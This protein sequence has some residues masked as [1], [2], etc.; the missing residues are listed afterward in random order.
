MPLMVPVVPCPVLVG[1]SAEVG[2]L[3]AA[4]DAARA[5]RGGVVFVVG[6]AGIGKSRLV[7]EISSMAAA[8][9]V[10]VLRGRAVPGSGTA[11]F[12]PIAEALATV[13]PEARLDG[14][15]LEPWL[16]VLAAVVPTIGAPGVAVEAS[17]PVRG[18]AVL[19]LL[20][21]V[22]AP[23]GGLLLL[24]DLHWADPETLAVVEH[25]S[26]HLERAPV[27]CVAT[28]R[29]DA[30]SSARDL[31]RR[32]VSRRAAQVVE[33]GRLND[34]QVAAMVYG[35]TGGV[36]ADA[37]DRIVKLADGVPF[38]VEELLVSPGLPGSFADAV[39]TRLAE[40]SQHDR[41]LL[42]TAAAFGRH[43]DWRLLTSATGLTDPEVVD[44][45]ERGVA[46][47]LLEVQ[48][49]GFRFRH[50]LTAEAVLQS[51]IPPRRESL[52]AAALA[53][54]DAAHD[55][56]SGEWLEVA[57]GLAERSRQPE[58]AGHL[59]RASGED[60]LTRG[61]LHTAVA[62]LA[63]AA[64]LLPAGDVQD[65]T[66][67]RLIE[68]LALVGRVDDALGVGRQL[69]DRLPA[70]RAAAVHLRLAG[71]A[72]TA[73]RWEVAAQQLAAAL[74]LVEAT[75][76][77]SLRA[78]L[79]LRE[80]ELAIGSGDH[81]GA[82]HKA[83][84][85]LDLA[86]RARTPD[87]ECA[88][89]QLLGRCARR[90]SLESAEAWFRDALAT[91]DA[92]ERAVWRLHA[93]HELGTIRLLD[94]SAVGTLVEA[95]V[96]A[97]SLGAMAT[98]AILD[99]ELAAGYHGLHDLEGQRRHG[100]EAV[101]RGTELAL[102]LVVAYGW[103]HVA[104]ASALSGDLQELETAAAAAHTAAP[105]NRDID[106]LLVAAADVGTALLANDNERALA[107][108]ERGAALLRGSQ[109]A[110]PMHLRAAWPL[111]LAWAHRAEAPAAVAE[112]EEAGVA[113]SR[114][115]RGALLMAEAMVTG[116]AD[117]DRAA[118]LALNGDEQLANVPLWRCM[119]RRLAAEAAASDGWSIP[120][121]WLTD[122][123]KWLRQHGYDVLADACRSLQPGPRA[124]VPPA[125]SRLG[126]T[127]RE[128]DVLA[129]VIEGCPNREIAERLF[130]S[131]RTVEKH[132][133][134][135]LRKTGT[136]TRTQ[137]ARVAATT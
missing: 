123:E 68:A 12:R 15:H 98:A 86:R 137:L 120:D 34:A 102:E 89:L 126:V 46:A 118:E 66:H 45:L 79:S 65:Q 114:A 133:E 27:L 17:V 81:A 8:E 20:S 95:Q 105:G 57:A 125:W 56:L 127:R 80:G 70:T 63:R 92:H 76:S 10:L 87:V 1:R 39:E 21:S 75:G 60:A 55:H 11:A 77:S 132:V 103:Q 112:L 48:G 54:L 5:G 107:A 13:V 131:V 69:V 23:G 58:R 128:A 3:A 71:A 94:R 59:Y 119:T 25:L 129:L 117:P 7:R 9:G 22:A 101:R 64:D 36:G 124:T 31:L 97:E 88:A 113:V 110:P 111:L 108:A 84:A 6:E 99:V 93:L 44:G 38:L 53:A 72:V 106:G 29:S 24:E 90:T 104:V 51:V 37:V 74:P 73:A 130:L 62:A 52:A 35:C 43:F 19:R 134:S 49:D 135:L 2:A 100:L 83:R 50:A 116:R 16:P 91:A 26:D 78:E 47:Q 85:A 115:G 121:E 30:D 122:A 41:R 136:R 96:L 18:E 32:V 40:L 42:A 28:V 61:A 14:G 4:L 67:E 33:L 82:E 109:T